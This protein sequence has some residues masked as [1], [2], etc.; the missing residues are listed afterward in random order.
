MHKLNMNM[1]LKKIDRLLA[2]NKHA[3]GCIYN[4]RYINSYFYIETLFV[5]RPLGYSNLFILNHTYLPK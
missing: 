3:L 2:M 1:A 4:P 5:E